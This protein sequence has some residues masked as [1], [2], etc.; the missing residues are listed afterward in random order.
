MGMGLGSSLLGGMGGIGS[1]GG[2]NPNAGNLVPMLTPTSMSI[3][4]LRI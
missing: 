1:L 4:N 2:Y 3:P